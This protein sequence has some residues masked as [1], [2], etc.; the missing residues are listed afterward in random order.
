[1][2]VSLFVR[3]DNVDEDWNLHDHNTIRVNASMANTFVVNAVD[4]IAKGVGR[5]VGFALC[6]RENYHT[7]EPLGLSGKVME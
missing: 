7:G 4:A 5:V 2:V 1:L 3:L 6:F